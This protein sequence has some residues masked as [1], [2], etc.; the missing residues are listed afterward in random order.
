[1]KTKTAVN[2]KGNEFLQIIIAYEEGNKLLLD[3]LSKMHNTFNVTTFNEKAGIISQI[4]EEYF[5][6]EGFNGNIV[7]I[8]FIDQ[9]IDIEGDESFIKLKKIDLSKIKICPDD[10]PT[11]TYNALKDLEIRNLKNLE[12]YLMDKFNKR[13][14]PALRLLRQIR[15]MGD[16]GVK[17]LLEFIKKNNFQINSDG[18]ITHIK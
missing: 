18:T 12:D 9:K 6:E 2:F 10:F 16:K 13:G 4:L 3:L 11:L 5:R 7:Q 17:C 15:Y 8:N 1:M 14:F